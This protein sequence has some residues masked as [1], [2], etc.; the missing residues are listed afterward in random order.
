M[1][2]NQEFNRDDAFVLFATFGGDVVRTAHALNVRSVDVLRCAEDNGWLDKLAPIL[3]LKKSTRPGD[4]ERAINRSLNFAQ[5]HRMRLFVSRILNRLC[6]MSADEFETYLLTSTDAKGLTTPKL[7]TRAIA[8]LA[9]ALEKSQAMS[10]QA[11]G[12]TAQDRAKRGES[13]EDADS[14]MDI[15][16][17]IAAA[18]ADVKRE[19]TPRALLFDEQLKAGEALKLQAEADAITKSK[20][21]TAET[22][23]NRDN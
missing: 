18:V 11:L 12:D 21:V 2:A 9:S 14:Q 17:R 7:S 16:A 23:Y 20:P 8:D 1:E 22:A 15:H 10:Y 13:E 3:T 5:A 6:G 4:F 19:D